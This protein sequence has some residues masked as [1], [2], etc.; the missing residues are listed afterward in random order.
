MIKNKLSNMRKIFLIL[1]LAL[2]FFVTS[3][4]DGM[5][6]PKRGKHIV[7]QTYAVRA[8]C[9]DLNVDAGGDEKINWDE[10]IKLDGSVGGDYD[11]LDWDCT[12]GDLSNDEILRPTFDPPNYYGG[13]EKTYTC[14]LT[15]SN[16]CDKD[17]DSMKITVDYERE[18]SKFRVILRAKPQ[19]ACAPADDVDL[20]ATLEGYARG[21]YEYTYRFDCDN[22]GDWEK[23]VITEDTEYIAKDLC[24]Y[25]N[26]DSYTARVRVEGRN[27]TVS[28]TYLIYAND[29][30]GG[31]TAVKKTGQ[32][33]ITK[34][35]RNVSR[36]TAFGGMAAAAPSEVIS[37]KIVVTGISGT[38]NNVFVRDSLPVGL[39]DAGS[40]RMDGAALA[41]SLASGIDIGTLTAGQIKD[42]TYS[43]V[44]AP[45][46]S[47]NFGNTILTNIATV[48]AGN[49]SADSHTTVNVYRSAV[50][51][52]TE[53]P[54]GVGGEAD[55]VLPEML[56][57]LAL[58]F[59]VVVLIVKTWLFARVSWNI[60]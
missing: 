19:L 35:V 30:N 37:Y 38:S 10:T 6:A 51:G 14:T 46:N 15:A 44:V 41:G 32:V 31:G 40:L 9:D 27:R 18:S 58:M 60:R 8:Y 59:G 16:D 57:F 17:S 34:M 43:A 20:I 53:I 3:A 11:E 28:D 2:A 13:D 26:S 5:A 33:S 25:R 24:D 4:S 50:A 12:G 23:T 48:T 7:S 54:T 49:S 47:F 1:F 22:D 52:A 36:N 45:K 21:D 29:C 55:N 39:V 56:L 42:I